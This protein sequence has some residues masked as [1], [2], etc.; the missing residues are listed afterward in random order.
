[1]FVV[2][3]TFQLKPG[4]KKVFLPL[5][6]ENAEASLREEPGCRQFDVCTDPDRPEEVFLYEIYDDAAAFQVHLETEH[7][8]A[9]DRKIAG[10]VADKSVKTYRKVA[11]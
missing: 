5:M 7:F 6:T 1:M 9:F 2:T 10:M 8:L 11:Q 3:V 4:Q